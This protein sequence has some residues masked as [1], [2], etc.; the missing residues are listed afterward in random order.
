MMLGI[1]VT[2]LNAG[3][4]RRPDPG[5]RPHPGARHDR[6]GDRHVRCECRRGRRGARAAVL[7]PVDDPLV[8]DDV[9]ADRLD[10]DPLAVRVRPAGRLPGHRDERRRTAA[11]ALHRLATA[12]RR[13]AGGLRGG[14][15]RVVLAGDLDVGRPDGRGGHGRR[16]EPRRQAAGAERARARPSPRASASPWPRCSASCS[17]PSPARSSACSGSRTPT[18]WRSAASCWRF[19]SVSGLFVT[20]ALTYTGALQGSGDTRSPLV[21]SII[22]QIVVPLGMCTV[23]QALGHLRPEGIWSAIVA[24]HITRATLS[25]ARFQQGKWQHIV[26][27]GARRAESSEPTQTVIEEPLSSARSGSTMGGLGGT[28]KRSWLAILAVA[29]AVVSSPARPL[30]V[31]RSESTSC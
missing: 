17:L 14:L 5:P 11:P 22:S 26:V 25:V 1:A 9:V 20:V 2:I 4:Q 12:Q 29:L 8:P 18:C 21:I 16:T 27:P 30:P 19:L 28:M 7:G 10:R 24:G 15:R 23:L 6:G 3:L 31:L 13:G